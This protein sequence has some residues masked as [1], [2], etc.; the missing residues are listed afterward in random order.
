MP[1]WLRLSVGTLTVL[2]VPA[3]RVVDKA[4]ARGAM[5]IAPLIGIVI[6]GI[7]GLPLAL[8]DRSTGASGLLL[9]A[10]A[11][12]AGALVTRALHWD[13]LADTIDA[14]GSGRDRQ[15]SLDIA[16]QSDLGPMGALAIVLVAFIQVGGLTAL[17]HVGVAY[18]V[19]IL[20]CAVGRVGIAIACTRGVPAAR[21]DGLGAF[22]ASTVPAPWSALLV[23]AVTC[24][25]VLG[26][27]GGRA[28]LM[29][30]IVGLIATAEI[31]RRARRTLGGITGDVLGAV[32]ESTTACTIA[33]ATLIVAL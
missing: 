20:A 25:G 24:L 8:A 29:A 1:D 9:A 14:L 10:L 6:G 23:V 11:V 32:V 17:A 18:P 33:A 26:V 5:L 7:T 27:L 16:R 22:V 3:P 2:T 12:S 28:W 21:A 19:W 13:G 31:V 30:G 4:A 15:G